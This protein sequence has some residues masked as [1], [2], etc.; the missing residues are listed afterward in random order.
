MK[1]PEIRRRVAEKNRAITLRMYREH[2]ELKEKIKKATRKA[3]Q[4]PEVI[5]KTQK[6][7]FKKGERFSPRTEFK[8]GNIPW[9]KGKPRP[10]KTK[11]KIRNTLREFYKNN[12]DQLKKILTF[13]R[14]NKT[15]EMLNSWL[16]YYFP[17]H[18]TFVGDGKVVI[19]GLNPDWID[20]DGSN[21]IIELF[22]EPWHRPEEEQT[23]KNR[24]AKF[25]YRTLVIW[26]E[27]LKDKKSVLEKIQ[28]FIE[29]S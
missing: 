22:G 17:N 24:F 11:G 6:T 12:P 20:C 3:M 1:N 4:R 23:R 8:K 26:Y 18:F 21:R 13:R 7:W 10:I 9:T 27:E 28:N 16:R 29:A 15:E 25:G 19:E 5:A 2:P 14:P